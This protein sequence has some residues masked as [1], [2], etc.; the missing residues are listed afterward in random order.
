MDCSL[1]RSTSSVGWSLG[2][3]CTGLLWLWLLWS[4]R[5]IGRCCLLVIMI[6]NCCCCGPGL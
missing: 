4:L 1:V 6:F 2:P 3:T 5:S